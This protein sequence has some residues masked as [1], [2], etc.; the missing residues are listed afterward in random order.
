MKSIKK[1]FVSNCVLGVLE[2][3]LLL[4]CSPLVDYQ[5]RAVEFIATL[6]NSASLLAVNDN[7]EKAYPLVAYSEN[8]VIKI[9]D[10]K[11]KKHIYEQ[12][13]NGE[14][15]A[16][17]PFYYN[18]WGKCYNL[19]GQTV[20][21]VN[22]NVLVFASYYPGK[23]IN[24]GEIHV[25]KIDKK[26]NG[27]LYK[28]SEGTILIDTY[29]PQL[30]NRIVS[31]VCDAD[32]KVTKY[33]PEGRYDITN[34]S[35]GKYLTEKQI[36]KSDIRKIYQDRVVFY[37]NNSDD[38]LYCYSSIFDRTVSYPDY[39]TSFT[40]GDR[41]FF[42]ERKPDSGGREL[43]MIDPLTLEFKNLASGQSISCNLFATYITVE[44]FDL[45]KRYFTF[46]GEEIFDI[47]EYSRKEALEGVSSILDGVLGLFQ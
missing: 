38:Q 37:R 31:F 4:A 39:Y 7:V 27:K 1:K 18:I 43:V 22:S 2:W 47:E 30:R 15:I 35:V 26:G 17:L 8:G 25:F 9:Y 28:D 10:L 13:T 11:K 44:G 5:K 20:A 36:K 24:T 45:S 29:D 42:Y 40:Q 23:H 46:E 6:G 19:N 33:L 12:I 21:G 3:S 32:G 14:V 34:Q 41:Y 16:V